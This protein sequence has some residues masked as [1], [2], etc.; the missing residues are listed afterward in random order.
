MRKGLPVGLIIGFGLLL[1]GFLLPWGT[2]TFTS[3]DIKINGAPVNEHPLGALAFSLPGMGG[4]RQGTLDIQPWNH[5]VDL[6]GVMFPDWLVLAAGALLCAI[7]L[8]ECFPYTRVSVL[9]KAGFGLYGAAHL[10]MVGCQ[11]ANGGRPGIGYILAV[12]A[13]IALLIGTVLESRQIPE[14]A[15][16][17]P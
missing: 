2:V 6:R 17:L 3:A 13:F 7:G 12:T 4:G 8:M 16:A 14:P 9:A 5:S 1:V 15:L 10:A 11:F